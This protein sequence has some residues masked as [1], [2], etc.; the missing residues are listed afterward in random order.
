MDFSNSIVS[1]DAC[2]IS[3]KLINRWLFYSKLSSSSRILQN[4]NNHSCLSNSLQYQEHSWLLYHTHNII[5]IVFRKDCTTISTV[6]TLSRNQNVFK[7]LHASQLSSAF[8]HI[9]YYG[10]KVVNKFHSDT[11]ANS[12]YKNFDHEFLSKISPP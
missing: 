6:S 11:N 12:F 5:L 1:E 10:K 2:Q 4:T 8:G 3:A 7:Y 9:T